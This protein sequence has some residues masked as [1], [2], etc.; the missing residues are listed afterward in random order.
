M[1]IFK[2]GNGTKWF[3]I[4]PVKRVRSA[5]GSLQQ[6]TPGRREAQGSGGT[7]GGAPEA[8]RNAVPM[9]THHAF[10]LQAEAA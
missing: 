1:G 3:S 5:E 2:I 6:P 10:G 9:V 7:A 4:E 8:G